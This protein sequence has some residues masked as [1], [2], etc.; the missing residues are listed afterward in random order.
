MCHKYGM[1]FGQVFSK[2]GIWQNEHDRFAGDKI[3]ILYD[4]GDFPAFLKDDRGRNCLRCESI[5][6]SRRS[7]PHS[8]IAQTQ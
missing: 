1:K 6:A 4:P 7:V 8:T 5:V 3:G 2:Y